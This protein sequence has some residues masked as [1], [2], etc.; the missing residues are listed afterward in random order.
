MKD[1]FELRD[2]FEGSSRSVVR[3]FV[4]AQTGE[5]LPLLRALLADYAANPPTEEIPQA[6]ED[7]A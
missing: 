3:V 1:L 6:I 4:S 5:G 2:A 7:L